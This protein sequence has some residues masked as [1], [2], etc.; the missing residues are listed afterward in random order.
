M[1][2]L[3]LAAAR[4]GRGRRS[5]RIYEKDLD[6]WGVKGPGAVARWCPVWLQSRRGDRVPFLASNV[7]LTDSG[8]DGRVN[9]SDDANAEPITTPGDTR[10][11]TPVLARRCPPPA[12]VDDV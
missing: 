11:R 3:E 5:N 7:A 10:S 2:K 6:V 4:T 12:G 8:F 9:H 1:H